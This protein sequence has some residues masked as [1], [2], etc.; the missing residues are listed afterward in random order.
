VITT[1]KSPLNELKPQLDPYGNETLTLAKS[2]NQ[3]EQGTCHGGKNLL[4][5]RDN[6]QNFRI[7][8]KIYMNFYM[9]NLIL[10]RFQLTGKSGTKY[11]FLL[12]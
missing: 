3:A 2:P 8:I 6:F 9:F 7:S 12:F 5:F 10:A 11:I 1:T 4:E